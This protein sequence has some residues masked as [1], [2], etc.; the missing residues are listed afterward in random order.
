MGALGKQKNSE[1]RKKVWALKGGGRSR[2]GSLEEL[3][4]TLSNILIEGR[5][6][7]AVDHFVCC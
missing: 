3:E 6:K 1:V 4:R 5:L 2:R 7:C